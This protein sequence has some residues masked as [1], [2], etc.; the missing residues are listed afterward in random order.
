MLP[1]GRLRAGQGVRAAAD[2]PRIIASRKMGRMIF[3]SK[4]LLAFDESGVA[5]ATVTRGPRGVKIGGSVRAPLTPGALV[6]GPLEDNVARPQELREALERV[7]RELGSDGRRTELILPDGTA[8]LQ[9]LDVPQGVR[10]EE[11]ARFR[12]PQGLPFAASEALVD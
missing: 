4:V 9:L 3:E 1:P 2:R 12:L 5:A 10:P 7:H 11:F 8:R 6:P